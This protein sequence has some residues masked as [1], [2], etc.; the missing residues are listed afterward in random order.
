MISSRP[1]RIAGGG[2]GRAVGQLGRGGGLVAKRPQFGG[3]INQAIYCAGL[4]VDEGYARWKG[5]D[6]GAALACL[7]EGLRAITD[8]LPMKPTTISICCASAPAT[9]SCGSRTRLP[10]NRLRVFEAPPPACCS[11]LEPVKAAR[12]PSTSSDI[13][14]VELLEFEFVAGLGDAQFHAH[15]A[16]LKTSTYGVVRLSFNQLRL[17]CRL[18]SAALDNLVEVVGNS[19]DSYP[20]PFLQGGTLSKLLIRCRLARRRS[21]ADNWTSN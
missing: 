15:E 2:R 16:R 20:L 3:R 11:S 18:R 4:L 9:R 17:Q 10:A 5:G 8:C 6:N 13:V 7:V 12:L 14:W 21:I 19:A 1:S